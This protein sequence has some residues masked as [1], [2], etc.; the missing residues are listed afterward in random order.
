MSLK[1]EKKGNIPLPEWIDLRENESCPKILNE[2]T[3][4]SSGSNALSNVIRFWLRKQKKPEYQPSRLYIYYFARSL[5]NNTEYDTGICLKNLFKAIQT[6]GICSEKNWPYDITKFNIKPDSDIPK[7]NI[8]TFKYYSV[9]N[10]INNLKLILSYGYPIIC[11]L[12]FFDNNLSQIM[13]LPKNKKRHKFKAISIYGYR[14]SSNM[15]ICMNSLGSEWGEKGFFYV[16]YEYMSKYG[17]D[18][19]TIT[20]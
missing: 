14:D 20:L 4:N 1:K 2:E 13:E 7:E 15:F 5:D 10:K 17:Y 19:W 3:L 12:H 6:F 18:F 8:S 16:P 9:K 11:M